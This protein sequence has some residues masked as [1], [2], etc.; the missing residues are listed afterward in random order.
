[1]KSGY[2][3]LLFFLG[4]GGDFA[5]MEMPS[6]TCNFYCI[7]CMFNCING[8]IELV[9]HLH[10]VTVICV[11]PCEII[12]LAVCFQNYTLSLQISH[13][14]VALFLWCLKTCLR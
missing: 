12:E 2:L 8:L 6:Q 13:I 3:L 10:L 4:G 11:S 1:M 14:F 9:F 7:D 5:N